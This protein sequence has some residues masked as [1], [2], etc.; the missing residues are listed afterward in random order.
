[1]VSKRKIKEIAEKYAKKARTGRR[2]NVSR[3]PLYSSMALVPP[4]QRQSLRYVEYFNLDPGASGYSTYVFSA[5]GL[6]DPNITGAGHQPRGFDQYM[7]LYNQYKVISSSI[8]MSWANNNSSA[9]GENLICAVFPCK[10]AAPTITYP[11]DLIEPK[12]CKYDTFCPGTTITTIQKR[13]IRNFV[14]IAQFSGYPSDALDDDVLRGNSGT[15][16][17]YQIYWIVAF[18]SDGG[19][20]ITS[21]N[22]IAEIEYFVEFTQPEQV[23]AS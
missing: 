20:N 6:Y 10:Q 5:N 21:T 4:R 22:F 1:M 17:T 23:G 15:N 16:P 9:N 14:N 3:M 19:T 8:T 2:Y 11:Y 18:G 7:A 12:G 13:K